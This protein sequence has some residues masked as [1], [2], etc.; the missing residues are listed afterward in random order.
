M[1]GFAFKIV[2]WL[3]VIGAIFGLGFFVGGSFATSAA[4]SSQLQE[5]NRC[6][7]VTNTEQLQACVDDGGGH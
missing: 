4:K 7:P 2:G 5:I 6:L 3:I 1:H